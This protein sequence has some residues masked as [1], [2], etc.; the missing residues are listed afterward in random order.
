MGTV[1]Y[2][3]G[4][5]SSDSGANAPLLA[6]V[7]PS[8][9]PPPLPAI[10]V[11]HRRFMSTA[12]LAG[13][14]GIGHHSQRTIVDKLRAL[15]RQLGLPLPRNPRIFRGIVQIGAASIC[16]ASKWDRGEALAWIDHGSTPPPA[17]APNPPRRAQERTR[18]ALAD[19]AVAAIAAGRRRRVGA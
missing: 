7:D 5:K 19:R 14:L 16:W 4:L 11:E 17:L 8:T 9:E 3:P 13:R 12:E 2:L 6:L 15:H 18:A 10:N 1:H